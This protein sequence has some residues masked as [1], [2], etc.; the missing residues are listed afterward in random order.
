MMTT[1]MTL[2]RQQIKT[3]FLYATGFMLFIMFCC[4]CMLKVSYENINYYKKEI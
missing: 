1:T 3:I 4:F 2:N